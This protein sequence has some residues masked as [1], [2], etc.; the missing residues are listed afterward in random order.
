MKFLS[1]PETLSVVVSLLSLCGPGLCSGLAAEVS[2]LG[3]LTLQVPMRVTEGEGSRSNAGS[4][5]LS[6][7]STTNVVVHLRSSAPQHV[8]LPELVTIPAGQSQADFDLTIP[9]N[10]VADGKRTVDIDAFS[11]GFARAVVQIVVAE[12]DIAR[13]T[14][15]PI[16]SP[17]YAGQP[18]SITITAEDSQG[19]R[20]ANFTGTASLRT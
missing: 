11:D 8:L 15:N 17:Q 3:Q 10:G 12:N 1:G 13:F 6:T 14:F 16:S 5:R 4:I 9:D 18:V 7:A 20:V 2:S 19:E